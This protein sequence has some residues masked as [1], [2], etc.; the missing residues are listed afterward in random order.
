M[1]EPMTTEQFR[2]LSRP[3]KIARL[4]EMASDPRASTETR[5]KLRRV[6]SLMVKFGNRRNRKKLN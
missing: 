4:M 6:A 2:Q 1:P 5:A 3:Q